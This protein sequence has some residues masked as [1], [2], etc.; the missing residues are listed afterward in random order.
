MPLP[1][2]LTAS[3]LLAAPTLAD[4]LQLQFQPPGATEAVRLSYPD[5]RPGPLPGLIAAAPDGSRYLVFVTLSFPEVAEG[6]VPQVLLDAEIQV[7][8]DA[9]RRKGWTLETTSRPRILTQQGVPAEIKHG[10]RVPVP[11]TNPVEYQEHAMSLRLIWGAPAPVQISHPGEVEQALGSRVRITGR[12]DRAKLG[13]MISTGDL[14]VTCPDFRVADDRV[15][16]TVTV[17]GRLERT[18]GFAATVAPDGAISQ[19]T[20]PGSEMLVLRDCRLP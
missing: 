9:G 10:A 13:D 12:V 15:G 20:P 6:A 3:V 1:L 7:L 4:D 17:E 8:R 16:T 19:G 11:G 2:F 18:A 14:A 5:V